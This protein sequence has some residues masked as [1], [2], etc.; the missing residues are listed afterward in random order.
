[1]RT[2]HLI[3][4]FAAPSVSPWVILSAQ[5]NTTVGDPQLAPDGRRIAFIRGL[6]RTGPP[7]LLVDRPE[8]KRTWFGHWIGTGDQPP[9]AASR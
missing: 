6:A 7:W 9:A 8:R 2:R 5:A 1:M 4:C 3:R